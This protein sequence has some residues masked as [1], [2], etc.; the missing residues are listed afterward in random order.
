MDSVIVCEI[1][2]FFWSEWCISSGP[3]DQSNLVELSCFLYFSSPFSFQLM[4]GLL[5]IFFNN[6]CTLVFIVFGTLSKIRCRSGPVSRV[7]VRLPRVWVCNRRRRSNIE[8]TIGR[9]AWDV[10]LP[11]CLLFLEWF[12]SSYPRCSST[13]GFGRSCVWWYLFIKVSSFIETM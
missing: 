8:W 10:R 6:S 11:T 2:V 1:S 4:S 9:I 7:Q 12:A 5:F 13:G 3:H